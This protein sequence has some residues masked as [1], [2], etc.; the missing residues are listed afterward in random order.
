MENSA[1]VM[2]HGFHNFFFIFIFLWIEN[3]KEPH[4]TFVTIFTAS[5]DHFNEISPVSQC[6][7]VYLIV[8]LLDV[9]VLFIQ[10]V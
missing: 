3:S 6:F 4:K 2:F 10:F 7:L 8:R 9:V 1:V 5:F